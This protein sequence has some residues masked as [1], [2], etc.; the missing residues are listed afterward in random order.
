MMALAA[1]I[2]DHWHAVERDLLTMGYHAD[3]I[4]TKLDTC[5]LI[6]IV[7]AAPP[8]TAVHHADPTRWSKT[9]E[10]IANLGEQQAGLLS[11]DAR[12]AR[13]Q[14]DSSPVKRLTE[15]DTLAPYKG[16]ALDASPVDEFTAKLKARQEALRKGQK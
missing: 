16:I 15:F 4:G 2:K 9:E 11:L 1:A 3:D 6:S 5:E 13:P 10:L 8:G 12:Y 14:V 7:V